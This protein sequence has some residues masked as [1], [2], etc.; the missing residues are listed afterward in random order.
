MDVFYEIP[1]GCAHQQYIEKVFSNGAN[2]FQIKFND[3]KPKNVHDLILESKSIEIPKGSA[4]IEDGAWRNLLKRSKPNGRAPK[5]QPIY[6][7]NIRDTLFCEDEPWN[8]DNF[9]FEHSI[10]HGLSQQNLMDGIQKPYINIG[11]LYTWFA[12][13]CEDSDLASVNYLHAGEPKYWLCVPKSEAEKMK[14]I[15]IDSLN[16]KYHYDCDTVYRHKCFIADEALLVQHG[17]KYTKLIQKPGEFV[18]TLYGA[19][20]WGYNGGFNICE[21]MNLA[22]PK[23][24]Q[25]YEE[26]VICGPDCDY[27]PMPILVRK[28]LGELL[29]IGMKIG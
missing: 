28:R 24:R 20:H 2:V 3:V 22:S 27:S 1:N 25:I 29:A 23:F 7:I 15:L 11:M 10:I 19:F 4:N 18:F 8:F 17:I 13:H 26:A 9:D 16:T 21:S 14:T 6:A 12:M 5:N